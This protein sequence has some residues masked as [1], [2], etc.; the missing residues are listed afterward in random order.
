MAEVVGYYEGFHV[1][2]EAFYFLEVKDFFSNVVFEE[3]ESAL[4]I[5]NSIN[6]KG[7][8]DEVSNPTNGSSI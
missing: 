1:E 5:F 8:D 2:A 3:F 6:E 7:A 4:S